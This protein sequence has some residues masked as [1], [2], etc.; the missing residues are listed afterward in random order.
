MDENEEFEFRARAEAEA[1]KNKSPSIGS[2][3]AQAG[4][5]GLGVVNNFLSKWISGP[6]QGAT[7][8]IQDKQPGQIL[9]NMLKG[10]ENPESVQPA[11]K[12]FARMGVSDVEQPASTVLPSGPNA[13]FSPV[14]GGKNPS[15]AELLGNLFQM[16]AN[17]LNLLPAAGEVPVLGKLLSKAGDIVSDVTKIPGK[18]VEDFGKSVTES[19]IKPNKVLKRGPS[20]FNIENLFSDR[21]NVNGDLSALSKSKT[22]D[23]ISDYHDQLGQQQDAILQ[24][25]PKVNLNGSISQA[26]QQINQALAKGGSAALGISGR[27]ATA[28]KNEIQEW[29]NYAGD[30][31]N[32]GWVDGETAKNFRGSLADAAK[33][34]QTAS[35]N[36]KRVVAAT[37]RE[38]LNDQIG[39]ISPE[40]RAIDKQFSETIPLRNA[41]ADATKREANKYPIGLRDAM[42]LANPSTLPA[43]AAELALIK[44]TSTFPAGVALTKLGKGMQ[45]IPGLSMNP[46]NGPPASALLQMLSQ[47]QPQ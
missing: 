32:N 42:V 9:P 39:N 20:P 47:G 43:K 33:Y 29:K 2:R 14:G 35:S 23:N 18:A 27:D 3:I 22:L 15:T 37:V 44:G 34:D 4:L 17:P 46:D 45:S 1:D 38:N 41:L 28:L 21:P 13:S 19:A 12:A 40:F 5:N 11:S 25:M 24:T 10:F 31:S 36:A 8:A 6:V 7:Q 16:G 26:E 30:I